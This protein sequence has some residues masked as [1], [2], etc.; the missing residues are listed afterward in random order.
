MKLTQSRGGLKFGYNLTG[1][2]GRQIYSN[3]GDKIKKVDFTK[4]RK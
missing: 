3:I 1:L 2:T 4:L